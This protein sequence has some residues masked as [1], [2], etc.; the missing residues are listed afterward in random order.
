MKKIIAAT[1]AVGVGIAGFYTLE[2]QRPDCVTVY[3]D[4]GI[5][6][7]DT[8]MT[9]CISV[10]GKTNALDLLTDAG[11]VIEGTQKY[12]NAVVCRVN[13]R[14]DANKESCE[15]MPPAEAYWAVLVKEYEIIP[16]P[17]NTTG[18]WGWAQTGIDEVYLN[19]GDSIGLVFSNN[20]E[21]KFP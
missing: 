4:Y 14:P 10:A 21:V 9:S 6:D 2:A 19:P 12:G 16:I 5:T 1:L 13:N 7:S 15:D 3:L 11:L 8:K 17:F 18:E 20:G